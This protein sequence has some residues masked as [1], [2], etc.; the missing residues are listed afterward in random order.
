[1]VFKNCL[2]VLLVLFLWLNVVQTMSKFCIHFIY[3]FLHAVFCSPVAPG[4]PSLTAPA[5][6]DLVE[7]NNVTFT[8][9][10]TGGNPTPTF[11]WYRNDVIVTGARQEPSDKFGT[12]RSL[13]SWV[14]TRH[15]ND[16]QFTCEVE[17][18]AIQ[19]PLDDTQQI[20]VK[21]TYVRT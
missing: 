4:P 10:T 16:A 14:L 9:D 15:D 6:D 19:F 1:M 7:N 8:C 12:A 2:W 13:L 11:A 5:A 21:C 18:E 3:D 20:S 17:N